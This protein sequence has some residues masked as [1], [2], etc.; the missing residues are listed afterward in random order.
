MSNENV[1]VYVELDFAV[2][3]LLAFHL[4]GNSIIS[5]VRD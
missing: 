2:G 5:A 1:P 4:S 3:V